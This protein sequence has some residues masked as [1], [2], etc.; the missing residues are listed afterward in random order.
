MNSTSQTK[1]SGSDLSRSDVDSFHAILTKRRLK[2]GVF[3]GIVDLRAPSIASSLT[4]TS[5][6]SPSSGPP[7]Q[8]ESSP[9]SIPGIKYWI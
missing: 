4:T 3:K 9:P 2:R 5:S 7:I 1:S 6:Q 8:I